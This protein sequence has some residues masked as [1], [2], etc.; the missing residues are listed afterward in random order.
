MGHPACVAVAYG[1][2]GI[3]HLL[4]EVFYFACDEYNI[5]LMYVMFT[6]SPSPTPSPLDTTPSPS[7]SPSPEA[8]PFPWPMIPSSC[9]ENGT[10]IQDF[11]DVS[12]SYC[13][14]ECMEDE[15]CVAVAH[16]GHGICHLLGDVSYFPCDEYN[17]SLMYVLFTPSS[18]SSPLAD[19]P[20]PSPSSAGAHRET[21]VCH[22]CCT[23]ERGL[24]WAR[25]GLAA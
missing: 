9:P 7:P 8:P 13:Q 22:G 3:C 12:L 1:G 11:T 6:P 20:S 10:T 23:T 18:S 4:D 25:F 24:L 5:Y 2:Q 14:S 17:I 15:G 21:F 16:G 19:T